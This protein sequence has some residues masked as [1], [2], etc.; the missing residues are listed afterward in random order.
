MTYY[1]QLDSVRAIAVI[2]V[3]ISHWFNPSNILYVCT[4]IFNRVDIFFVLSGFLIRRILLENR[5]L[6]EDRETSKMLIVKSFFIRRTLRIFLF[7][8]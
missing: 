4:S 5:L 8:T 7:I 3:I 2:L 1:K 6:A